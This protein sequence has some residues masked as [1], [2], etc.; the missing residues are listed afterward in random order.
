MNEYYWIGW[1][2]LGIVI[3][4]ITKSPWFLKEYK[5]W[6]DENRRIRK[7]IDKQDSEKEKGPEGP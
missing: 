3:G 4:W 5:K 1:I 6:E 7:W 2:L